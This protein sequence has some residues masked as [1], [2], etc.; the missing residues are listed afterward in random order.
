MPFSGWGKRAAG[1]SESESEEIM[2]ELIEQLSQ[3]QSWPAVTL[4]FMACIAFGYVF[5]LWRWFPNEAIPTIVILTGMAAAM[6]LADE[7]PQGTS[8]RLWH[9]RNA[10][11]GIAIGFIAWVSHA[12]IV[13]KIED[14]LSQKF[15]AV[16]RL[17]NYK[18]PIP[19]PPV[20]CDAVLEKGNK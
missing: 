7:R 1:E 15:S 3:V 5:R 6:L 20:N 2:K 8:L 4:V 18:Q 14:Y 19:A 12:L 9:A 11:V 17:L 13:S 10:F 16:D